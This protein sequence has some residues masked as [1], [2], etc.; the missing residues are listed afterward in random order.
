M[1]TLAEVARQAGVSPST[2]SYVLSRKRSISDDTRR[3][4]EAAIEALGYHPH[5]GARALASN[6]SNILALMVPLRSDMYVPVIMEIAMAVTTE[7]REYGQDV[8]LL[9]KD[10]GTRGVRRIAGSGLADAMILMDIELDDDRIPVLRET[11]TPAV[12]I[13]LPAD[14]AGLA[15]VDL[16]FEATGAA[17][18]DHLADLGHRDVALIGEGEGVYQRHT[19][20]AART[21]TG[22]QRRA[23]ERGLRAMHR[24]CEGTYEST[25]GILSRILEERPSTTGF[26]V[27][28]ES[29]IPP[30]LS[31]LRLSG[32]AVPEETSVVA[33]CPDQVALQSSPRLTSVSIPAEEMGRRAVRLAMAQLEGDRSESITLIPPTLTVRESTAPL[34][35]AGFVAS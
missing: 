28:N 6:R 10:E 7:A 33:I 27:Q 15:C 2:V 18:A 25:A 30:L 26:V 29:A 31:L 20:F 34:A 19:G 8:L 35:T 32:R 5:A 24:A 14:P 4:V 12:L 22:F 11:D 21:L 13:G 1:V 23:A 9:T 3:K 16:D 17:C